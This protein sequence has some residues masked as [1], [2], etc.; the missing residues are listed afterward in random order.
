MSRH[1]I[2]LSSG[3]RQRVAIARA[4][5]QAPKCLLCDE[6]TG[7]LDSETGATLLAM[8]NTLNTE[9]YTIVMITHDPK[10]AATAG[11]NRSY[12]RW[13]RPRGVRVEMIN[14]SMHFKT[15]NVRKRRRF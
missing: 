10:V 14:T 7:S 13:L 11:S 2:H 1:P 3:Q 6:P 4:L 5:I 8:L 9:G 12:R 15:S